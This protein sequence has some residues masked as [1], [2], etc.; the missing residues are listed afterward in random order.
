MPKNVASILGGLFSKSR[1]G[2]LTTDAAP[3]PDEP[4]PPPS[5]SSSSSPDLTSGGA[6]DISTS[7]TASTDLAK[8]R[9][10]TAEY[11]DDTGA[12]VPVENQL[13]NVATTVAAVACNTTNNTMAVQNT[14]GHH[15]YQFSQISGLHIGS[16][17]NIQSAPPPPPPNGRMATVPAASRLP[18]RTGE[19]IKRTTTID[20]LFLFFFLFI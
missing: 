9:E 3:L 11:V 20:G 6:A 16:V 15:V 10:S 13:A 7:S 8:L 5:S 2:K 12:L 17:F 19:P 14:Q 4:V 1:S 18:P